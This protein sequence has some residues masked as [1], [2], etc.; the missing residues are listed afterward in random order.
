MLKEIIA[1]LKTMDTSQLIKEIH[2]FIVQLNKMVIVVLKCY[3]LLNI[4]KPSTK[5][6]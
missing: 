1:R 4:L 2:G 6:L 3:N 5:E